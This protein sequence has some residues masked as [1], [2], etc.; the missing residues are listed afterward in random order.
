MPIYDFQCDDCGHSF[1]E[2]TSFDET[3]RCSSCGGE[4]TQKQFSF[5]E[6][7]DAS[8]DSEDVTAE[9]EVVAEDVVEEE[10]VAE[11]VV[12]EEVAESHGE[13]VPQPSTTLRKEDERSW[14]LE[15]AFERRHAAQLGEIA[16]KSVRVAELMGQIE[17]LEPLLAENAELDGM[18][19]AAGEA[20]QAHESTERRLTA[21]LDQRKAEL[22]AAHVAAQALH[23]ELV[24]TGDGARTAREALE[25]TLRERDH[26]IRDL[27]HQIQELTSDLESRTA[28]LFKRDE[29][30]KAADETVTELREE[31]RERERELRDAAEAHDALTSELALKATALSEHQAHQNELEQTLAELQSDL[32]E[33]DFALSTT[34]EALE[35]SES[36]KSE[37]ENAWASANGEVEHHRAKF[38]ASVRHLSATQSVIEELAPML[39]SLE[40]TLGVPEVSGSQHEEAVQHEADDSVGS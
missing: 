16:D 12:Q 32:R 13:A 30:I 27:D 28:A 40:T 19:A 34:S 22:E 20:N 15:R 5:G 2:L 26:H 25:N 10:V 7:V 35:T 33:M 3:P 8:E 36:E 1:E 37:L 24:E 9:E 38:L 17:K 14:D 23:A 21:D 29:M 39:R 11:D 31:I 4:H 18:L 6:T